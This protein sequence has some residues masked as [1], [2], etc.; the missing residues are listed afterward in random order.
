MILR[1]WVLTQVTLNL[2]C[3]VLLSKSSLNQKSLMVKCLQ[4]VTQWH[5]MDCHD[6]EVMSL[7]PGRVEFGMYSTSAQVVL[8][9]EITDGWVVSMG[10]SVTW[11]VLSWPGGHE[12]V[13]L[14]DQTLGDHV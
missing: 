14:L 8:E 5:E 4:Q 10:I 11:N 1:S 12:F 7:N 9:P 13:P 3:I 2:G 6:L